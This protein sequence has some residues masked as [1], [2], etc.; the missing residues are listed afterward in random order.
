M[1]DVKVGLFLTNQHPEGADMAR[2]LDE[3]I[4][5][6]NAARTGGWDSVWTGQHYLSTMSQL[7]PL[8]FLARLAAEAGEM[9]IGLG[10]QLLAL[11]NPLGVAEDMAAMDVITDGKFIYGA[12]LGYRDIEYAAFG[13]NDGSHVE[14]FEANLAIVKRLWTGESVSVDLPWCRLDR[15][16]LTTLPVQRPRPPIWLAANSDRSVARAARAADAWLI[17]PH[18]TFDTISRQLSLFHENRQMTGL[19]PAKTVPAIKEVFCAATRQEAVRLAM[20]YLAEKYRTY[21]DWGQDLVLPGRESF[22][23]PFEELERQRFI[24]GSPQDC[25]DRL[26][27]WRDDLGV[28]HFVMRTHWAGMPV[29]A[30]L[31]SIDILSRE[32]L[33]ELK[34]GRR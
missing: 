3:Q 10:I 20:P 4:A 21:A 23:M 6:L 26:L 17:N 32:V 33:P 11:Q 18:A 22:R 5:M 30:S 34:G 28:D 9:T 1:N 25:L 24:L 27:P 16:R 8:P 13:I 2:A 7:Q 31:R 14:R 12:G 29:E 15:A 19:P